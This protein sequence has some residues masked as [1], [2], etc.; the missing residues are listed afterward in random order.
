VLF[1]VFQLYVAFEALLSLEL[2]RPRPDEVLVP[3]PAVT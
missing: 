3:A 2:R 1:R